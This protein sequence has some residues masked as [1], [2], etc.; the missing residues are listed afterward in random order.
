MTGSSAA[1]LNVE[2]L[3]VRFSGPRHWFGPR[4][5][6][7]EAVHRVTFA[8]H[9]GET[10]GVVGESG[11]GKTT[12]ARALADLIP[13]S[14]GRVSLTGQNLDAL[15]APK[16][17]HLVRTAIR[18][19][20]QDPQATMNPGYP[21]G[22]GLEM[23]YALHRDSTEPADRAIARV[24]ADLDLPATLL[25]KYPQTLSGGEKRRLGIARALL[26]SPRVLIADE[27]LSGLDVV[28]Q[29][30]VLGIL[31]RE[32]RRR[33]FGLLLVSHDLDRVAQVCDRVLVMHS[34]RVVEDTRIAR[35][36]GRGIERYRHPYSVLLRRASRLEA[37][38]A[39]DQEAAPAG[40]ACPVLALCPRYQALHR[41]S[42]CA[43]TP[44]PVVTD[45]N[46]NAMACHF[47]GDD[48]G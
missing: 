8:L 40:T 36:D 3:T 5:P 19:L 14:E 32:Q 15:P 23:A 21:V 39:L 13:H 4:G 31:Q 26:T 6:S 47:P 46:G 22:R 18:L 2:S 24:L 7:V 9:S 41:P 10:I 28:L 25:Q 37:I 38:P 16:R 29:E 45:D 11:S 33:G 35:H 42:V 44:P 48:P 30:R 12:L 34:G 1:T 20:F 27:P 17:R 43:Q